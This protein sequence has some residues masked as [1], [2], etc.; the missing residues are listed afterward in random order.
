MAAG[1]IEPQALADRAGKSLELRFS[2]TLRRVLNGTGVLLHTNL[3]RSP[4][5]GSRESALDEILPG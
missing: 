1:E 2:P 5:V 4:L 3:G